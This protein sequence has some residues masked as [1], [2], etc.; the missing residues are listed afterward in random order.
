MI[1]LFIAGVKEESRLIG[2]LGLRNIL[3]LSDGRKIVK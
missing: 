1:V 2:F 3:P